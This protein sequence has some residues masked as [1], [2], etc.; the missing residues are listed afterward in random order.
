MLDAYLQLFEESYDYTELSPY[1]PFH[2]GCQT[3]GGGGWGA[4]LSL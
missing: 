1:D 3:G 4:V 2:Q